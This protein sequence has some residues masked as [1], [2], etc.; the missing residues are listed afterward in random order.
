M[1]FHEF[2]RIIM[3]FF[4]KENQNVYEEEQNWRP[5]IL[6]FFIKK[7]NGKQTTFCWNTDGCRQVGIKNRKKLQTS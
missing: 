1:N 4:K 3:N 6:F 5:W 2:L 7:T